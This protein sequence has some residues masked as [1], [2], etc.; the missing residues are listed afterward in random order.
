MTGPAYFADDTDDTP[1]GW[2]PAPLADVG[3]TAPPAGRLGGTSAGSVLDI[4][5]PHQRTA[6]LS[7][8]L[9]D[10]RPA[11]AMAAAEAVAEVR[12]G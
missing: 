2:A 9:G 7:R 5:T 6:A 11:V 10:Y 12:R 8:L 4:L 3:A 1:S